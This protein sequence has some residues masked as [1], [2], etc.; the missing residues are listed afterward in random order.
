MPTTTAQRPLRV[1][2]FRARS[3]TA[4]QTRE[5]FCGQVGMLGLT[6]VRSRHAPNAGFVLANIGQYPLVGMVSL[7]N[8]HSR[9]VCTSTGH[10]PGILNCGHPTRMICSKASLLKVVLSPCHLRTMGISHESGAL[11]GNGPDSQ[12]KK[13]HEI[14][15]Y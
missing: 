8:V 4:R 9:K 12:N 11:R 10:F 5:F 3:A 1:V 7:T 6:N 15:T 13:K 14:K 2:S